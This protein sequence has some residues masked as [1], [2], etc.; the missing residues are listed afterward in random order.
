MNSIKDQL[1]QFGDDKVL[2]AKNV[3]D[4]AIDVK[5]LNQSTYEAFIKEGEDDIASGRVYSHEEVISCFNQKKNA[6][7]Q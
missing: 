6:S 2:E 5:A 1:H 4:Y 3:M 7:T